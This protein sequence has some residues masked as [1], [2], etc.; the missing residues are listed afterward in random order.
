[1]AIIKSMY[2]RTYYLPRLSSIY[3]VWSCFRDGSAV[4]PCI[5]NIFLWLLLC[6]YLCWFSL[7]I[8]VLDVSP[9]LCP[10]DWSEDALVLLLQLCQYNNSLVF[11]CLSINYCELIS[12]CPVRLYVFLTSALLACH[13]PLIYSLR[14]CKWVLY[15][16]SPVSSC[17]WVYLLLH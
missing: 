10:Y 11:H 3:G 5:W 4:T 15:I 7:G 12:E 2:V 1:M 16:V 6:L 13:P 14:S 8:H 9:S 17:T